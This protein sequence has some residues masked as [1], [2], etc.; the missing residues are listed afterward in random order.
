MTRRAVIENATG[1]FP[2]GNQ[3]NSGASDMH[4]SP[5]LSVS[6]TT[7]KN[8]QN[9]AFYT[10]TTSESQPELPNL[11]LS[12]NTYIDVGKAEIGWGNGRTNHYPIP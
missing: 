4:A 11:S 6:N 12:N 8:L 7:F 2:H 10:Y 3:T 5:R 9:Y 1:D